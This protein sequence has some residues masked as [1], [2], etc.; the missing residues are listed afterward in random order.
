MKNELVIVNVNDIQIEVQPDVE[1]D[2]LL[3]TKDVAEGYGLSTSGLRSAKSTNA[4]ELEEGKHWVVRDTDTLG[5]KQKVT[6]WTKRG[7]VR[8]GFFIKTPMAKEFRDWAE[9]Y[10]INERALHVNTPMIPQ[11]FSDALKLAYEQSL[12]IEQLSLEN[13]V[14]KPKV[15]AYDDLHSTDS[16]IMPEQAHKRITPNPRVLSKILRDK[17]GLFYHNNKKQNIPTTKALEKGWLVLRECADR[18]DPSILRQQM[19]YTYE[20]LE[21]IH[22]IA[23]KYAKSGE[24]KLIKGATK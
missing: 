1:H 5:G 21:V 20:G 16:L 12:Q 13:T 4:D 9:D 11:N 23:K 24:L 3:S 17:E 8:L 19:M 22:K 15:D 14:M 2:W 6:M 18:D 7:V 10:I